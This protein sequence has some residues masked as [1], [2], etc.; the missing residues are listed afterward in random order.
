MPVDPGEVTIITMGGVTYKG[1]IVHWST[2]PEADQFKKQVEPTPGL[3]PMQWKCGCDFYNLKGH[4]C[5]CGAQEGDTNAS[6]H[7]S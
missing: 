3:G 2:C 4:T 5:K 6:R 7:K 1:R